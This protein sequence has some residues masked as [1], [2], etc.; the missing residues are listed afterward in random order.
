MVRKGVGDFRE[1]RG[2]KLGAS[3]SALKTMAYKNSVYFASIDSYKLPLLSNSKPLT[4][5]LLSFSFS[6]KVL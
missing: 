6:S 4:G 3:V 2:E 5:F 1:F